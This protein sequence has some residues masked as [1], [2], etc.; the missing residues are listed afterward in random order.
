MLAVPYA[1]MELPGWGRVLRLMGVHADARWADAPGREVRGK[2]HGYWMTLELSD[3][4][5]RLTYF[6]GR[7]YDLGTQLF[8]RSSV[9]EGD[10]FVDVGGNIGMITLLAARLVGERGRVETF[11]P[12]PEVF[13]RLS[14][15]VERNGLAGRVR[16]HNKALAD[17]PGE[18]TLSVLT[19]H[20]GMGTLSELK[21]KEQ[22][23]VSR[24]H[25]VSVERGDA[26]LG[27]DLAGPA[28]V[29]VDVEGFECRVLRGLD[30][31]LRRL[32]PAVV[33]E[34][35][36]G[37]LERAGASVKELFELLAGHGYNGYTLGTPRRG[38][39]HELSLRPV[40]ELDLR[41][42]NMA[43]VHPESVHQERL[44]PWIDD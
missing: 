17:E 35:S 5:E 30:G 6:L 29:K 42:N 18:L 20:S 7:F 8:V 24:T 14:G 44:A 15:C 40:K 37:H 31:T 32:R 38:L 25:R 19:E 2:W 21:G 16:L 3:W 28:T 36:P 26:L 22:A 34:V 27:S 13:H 1:R 41:G 43:W 12:N 10:S 4:S 39:R 33:T 11:E 9:R 23:M